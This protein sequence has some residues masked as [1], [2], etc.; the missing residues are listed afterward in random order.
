MQAAL[1]LG[2]ISASLELLR[3]AK[4]FFY[5]DK[6]INDA[7]AISHKRMA[8][9]VGSLQEQLRTHREVIDKLVEQVKAGKDLIEKHNDVLIQLSEATRE[10]VAGLAGLR[11]LSYCAIGL[12]GVSLCAAIL[13]VIF[14]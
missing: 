11:T 2:G 12:A 5:P 6:T 8:A 14:K 10:A 3:K 9:D 1:I 13:L 4:E 7:V